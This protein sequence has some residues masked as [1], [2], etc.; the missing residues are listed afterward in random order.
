MASMLLCVI[1][2]CVILVALR[3]TLEDAPLMID[4]LSHLTSEEMMAQQGVC[5]GWPPSSISL[6]FKAC[7]PPCFRHLFAL[8]DK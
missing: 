3:A 2:L 4:H 7:A 5:I 6:G 1:L 8:L